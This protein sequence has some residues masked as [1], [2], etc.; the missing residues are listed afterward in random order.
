MPA[1]GRRRGRGR[2]RPRA[3]RVYK[4]P[5]L[6]TKTHAAFL[7][8]FPIPTYT[9]THVISMDRVADIHHIWPSMAN[10]LNIRKCTQYTRDMAVNS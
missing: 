9:G 2:A 10:R 1:R 7:L 8:P 4:F 5:V 3:G 6:A